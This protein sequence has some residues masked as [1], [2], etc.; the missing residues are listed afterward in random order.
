VINE[1]PEA[2]SRTVSCE[3]VDGLLLEQRRRLFMAN[4]GTRERLNVAFIKGSLLFA[5]LVG[6]L[7]SSVTA[8]FIALGAALCCNLCAREIRFGGH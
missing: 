6:F 5:T 2:V 3:W 8:F 1:F 7:F 4:R